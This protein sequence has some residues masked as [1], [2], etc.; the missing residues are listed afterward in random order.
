MSSPNGDIA[1]LN[2]QFIAA[3][4]AALPVSDLGIVAAASV[5]EMIRTFRGQ[6]FRVH[7]HLQRLAHSIRDTRLPNVDL[8]TIESAIQQ[9]V[10][11]NAGQLP[12]DED[13]GIIIFVTA[14]PNPTYLGELGREL[15]GQ[16]TVCVHTFRLPF[17]FW[18]KTYRSGQSL[19]VSD[20]QPPDPTT[21]PPTAKFRSRLH[22]YIADQDAGSR[23]AGSRAILN[24][25][26]GLTET[27]A[28]NFFIVE[29]ETLVTP[30]DELVLNGISRE[31]AMQLA[32]SIGLRTSKEPISSERATQ[33]DEAFTTSTTYCL[34]PVATLNGKKIG[35]ACPGPVT[36][37]LLHAWNEMV[38]LDIIAQSVAAGQRRISDDP[39]PASPST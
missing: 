36:M 37:R 22:W 6:P 8:D 10:R 23:Q 34:L 2:G 32:S 12:P 16:P 33:S 4:R 17:E 31:V 19:R 3:G 13:L 11:H 30:P 35:H 9:V 18:M 1:Y 20:T 21:L 38:G 14:G 27:S 29:Q 24:S 26:H 39:P 25:H 28:G 7:E 5:T 15:F